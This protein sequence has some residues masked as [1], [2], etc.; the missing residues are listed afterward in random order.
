MN[1]IIEKLQREKLTDYQPVPFWS[2]NAKLDP[3]ELIRQIRWMKEC[4]IG[5]FFMH[6]RTGLKTEY[7]S[8]EWMNCVDICAEKPQ[9]LK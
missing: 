5:G 3:E 4:G 1:E 8:K 6:A 2:W 7:L 9:N